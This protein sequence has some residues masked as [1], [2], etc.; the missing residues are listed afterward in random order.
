MASAD[1]ICPVVWSQRMTRELTVWIGAPSGVVPS[2]TVP[3]ARRTSPDWSPVAEN[4][5]HALG[6]DPASVQPPDAG[7]KTIAL[8][9]PTTSTR[10]PGIAV[11]VW[12][13]LPLSARPSGTSE[14]PT[15]RSVVAL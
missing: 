14:V 15:Q 3:P 10:L 2:Y 7:S 12:T 1:L 4:C 9:A 8:W 11:T 13:S 6:N 5:D